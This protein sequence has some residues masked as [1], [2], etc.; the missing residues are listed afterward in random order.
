M[1]LFGARAKCI[2]V[3]QQDVPPPLH[4]GI[5]I[6]SFDAESKGAKL[7]AI[8]DPLGLLSR[9]AADGKRVRRQTRQRASATISVTRL[10]TM[11]RNCSPRR[12]VKDAM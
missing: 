6:L 1:V 12:A 3:C 7:E 5:S 11:H 8:E 9:S 2:K 4:A 10:A